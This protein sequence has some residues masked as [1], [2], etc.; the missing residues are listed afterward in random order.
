MNTNSISRPFGTFISIPLE[1][2]LWQKKIY[3]NIFCILLSS[4]PPDRRRDVG[5]N[6]GFINAVKE[7]C[8]RSTFLRIIT[9]QNCSGLQLLSHNLTSTTKRI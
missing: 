8:W 9:F 6:K 5:L 2:A 3:S 4:V 7:K 1:G